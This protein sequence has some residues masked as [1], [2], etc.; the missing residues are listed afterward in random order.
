[1]A[2]RSA[3]VIPGV[4]AALSFSRVRPTTSPASRISAISSS[5]LIW[6]NALSLPEG[7]ERGERSL[8]HVVDGTHGVDAHQDAGLGVVA[9]QRRR[10]FVVDLES[11][12][13][14]LRLVVVALGKPA[15]PRVPNTPPPQRGG[16]TKP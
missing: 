4:T 5:V 16:V 9:H 8:R 15:A 10:L 13:D 12:P 2:S 1:M 3:V 14:R 11:V 7:P 6:I